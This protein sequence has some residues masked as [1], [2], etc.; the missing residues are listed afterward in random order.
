[1]HIHV[2]ENGGG[3][4]E[5]GPRRGTPGRR[6]ALLLVLPA[7]LALISGC[8]DG[9]AGSPTRPAATS[10]AATP[11]GNGVDKL[12]GAEILKRATKASR[13]AT[14]VRMRGRFPTG[15]R[16]MAIDIRAAGKGSA[17]GD[18]TMNGQRIRLVRI[19]STAYLK[20]DTAFWKSVGGQ[21]AAR[22]FS[23]KYLKVPAGNK[24]FR[25]L[26]SLTLTSK[27]FSEILRP[28][29]RVTKGERTRINGRAAIA[30][31]DGTGGSLYVATEGE[32]H[33]LRL[34]TGKEVLDFLAYNERIAV[35]RPPSNRVISVPAFK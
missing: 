27:V 9:T 33:V 29:G 34:K 11:N 26:M 32:P 20:G 24:D 22:M 12:S 3:A 28:E 1:V 15:G 31:G 18:I 6:R 25:D 19:G 23:G 21:D 14:S 5:A 4:G 16:P 8:D 13:A 30:L 17:Y 35:R 10:A 7:A 2:R